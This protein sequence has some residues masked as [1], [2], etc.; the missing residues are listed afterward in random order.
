MEERL[1]RISQDR[2]LCAEGRVARKHHEVATQG[3]EDHGEAGQGGRGMWVQEA[4]Q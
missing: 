2:F 1:G 3:S 4:G